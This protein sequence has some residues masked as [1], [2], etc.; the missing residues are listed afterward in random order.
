MKVSTGQV[1]MWEGI[2]SVSAPSGHTTFQQLP[3]VANH[4][5][6]LWSSVETFWHRHPR[7]PDSYL[8]LLL[9][10]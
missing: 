6:A 10:G 8:D 5:E 2:W 7:S 9:I 4:P 1:S 3:R